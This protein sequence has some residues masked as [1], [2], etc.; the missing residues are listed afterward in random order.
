MIHCQNS[1][2]PL[3]HVYSTTMLA[4]DPLGPVGCEVSSMWIGL[5]LAEAKAWWDLGSLVA[6]LMQWAI[7]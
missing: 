1:S 7:C 5:V 4:A 6:L 3:G 2:D